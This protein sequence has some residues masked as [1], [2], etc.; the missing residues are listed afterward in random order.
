MPRPVPRKF[1]PTNP[2]KYVGDVNNIISRS[3]WETKLLKYMDL[4]ENVLK[5]ASEEVIVPYFSPVDKKMHRYFPDFIVQLK[6]KDGGI[7]TMMVE[8]KPLKETVPPV[9]PARQT[10]SY[11]NAVLTYV[12]NMAKWEAANAFCLNR[13]WKFQLITEKDLFAK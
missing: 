10:N 9:A 1:I 13:G 5:Y 6:Q 11:R 2:D 3:S 7:T 4:N 8:V 12:V